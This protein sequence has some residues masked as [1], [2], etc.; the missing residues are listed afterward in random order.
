MLKWGMFLSAVPLMAS[1]GQAQHMNARDSPCSA[2]AAT[3]DLYACF[4]DELKEQDAALNTYY[5]RVES[6][7]EGE[8][9][10]RLKTSQ[11]L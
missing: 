1:H 11:R 7:M 8:D 6:T 9:L 2:S 10:A 5:R 3:S 4:A